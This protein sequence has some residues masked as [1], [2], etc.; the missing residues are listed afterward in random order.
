MRVVSNEIICSTF[1]CV[2]GQITDRDDGYGLS[3]VNI[4]NFFRLQDLPEEKIEV[5]HEIAI[6]CEKI[7]DD[8]QYA[9]SLLYD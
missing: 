7:Q 4:E 2:R 1:R 3:A 9:N 8:D 6:A 5:K